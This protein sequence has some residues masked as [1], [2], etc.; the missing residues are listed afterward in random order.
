MIP[1]TSGRAAGRVIMP[2]VGRTARVAW[3]GMQYAAP[4]D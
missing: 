3:T 2:V 4:A 1:A